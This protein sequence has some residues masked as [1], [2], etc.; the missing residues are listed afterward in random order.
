LW[1]WDRAK[2]ET[3]DLKALFHLKP[4]SDRHPQLEIDLL[5]AYG[6]AEEDIVWVNEP[7]W[8]ESVASATPMWHNESPHYVDPDIEQVWDRLT[9]GLLARAPAGTPTPDRLFVSRRVT[10]RTCRNRVDVEE[11][12]SAR[13]FHIVFPELLSLPEQ[14]AMFAGASVVAGFA[15]S[16]MFNLMH[17]RNVKTTIVLSH[18]AY[19]ARNE[20]LFT[21]VRGGDAHYF[22][23]PSDIPHPEGGYLK[24]AFFSEWAFD[25][26]ANGAEL[27]AVIAGL[28]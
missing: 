10:N 20:H 27:D 4:Q 28:G 14:V 25:F 19:I 1:G 22:W 7:V 21:A 5:T 17:A 12:M 3:P 26:G 6:I 9:E 15:G 24:K 2:Q 8:L 16:N 11:F 23:S 18:D 13:G